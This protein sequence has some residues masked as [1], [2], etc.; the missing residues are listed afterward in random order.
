M[1]ACG[2]AA[3]RD[4]D[5]TAGRKVYG[6]CVACHG[7][8]GNGGVGPA[9]EDVTA[10][11]PDCDEHILWISLGSERW[12]EEVGDTY[13]A[14]GVLIDGVMPSFDELPERDRRLVAF[15]ERVTFAGADPDVERAA[16]GLVDG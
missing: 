3:P 16:C 14:G 2:E 9:L 4:P 5:I 1:A 15:Y 6:D 8:E 13:G 12:K 11:F 10:T 7:R